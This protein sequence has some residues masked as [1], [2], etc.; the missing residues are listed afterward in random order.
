LL[1]PRMGESVSEATIVK[2]LKQPGDWVEVDDTVLDI[3]TDKVDSEVPSP[4][5]GRLVEQLFSQ[6][7]VAQVGAVIAVLET[8]TTSAGNPTPEIPGKETLT[9]PHSEQAVSD[10]EA[11]S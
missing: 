2:W 8:E 4:V 10:V 5:A 11:E 3:A 1:L 6:D 9:T 7:E